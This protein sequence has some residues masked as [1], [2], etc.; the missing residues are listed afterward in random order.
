M[1]RSVRLKVACLPD[2]ARVASFHCRLGQVPRCR[3]LQSVS[4]SMLIASSGGLVGK[5][6]QYLLT[7]TTTGFLTVTALLLWLL[8]VLSRSGKWGNH[9][10][11]S[12]PWQVGRPSRKLGS[13][14]RH[15]LTRVSWHFAFFKTDGKCA[16]NQSWISVQPITDLY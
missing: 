15:L 6:K 8:D 9:N 7:W 14:E 11:W 2:P 3:L 5:G 1:W 16:V 10:H 4:A 13:F 12:T